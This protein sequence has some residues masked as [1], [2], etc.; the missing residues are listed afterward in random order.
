M[1][2]AAVFDLNQHATYLHWH[3]IDLS[4]SNV[5]VIVAMLVVFALAILAPFP[6]GRR[7]GGPQ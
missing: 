1:P 7:H 5:L 3:F 4:L 6:G 2:T